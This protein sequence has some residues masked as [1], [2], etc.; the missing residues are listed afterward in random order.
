ME[1]EKFLSLLNEELIIAL[2]CTE[3]TAIAIAAATARKY[4]LGNKYSQCKC[5]SFS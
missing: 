2:G 5:E 4:V 3:P 1:E